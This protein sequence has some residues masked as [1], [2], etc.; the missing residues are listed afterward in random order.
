MIAIDDAK[1]DMAAEAIDVWRH[2]LEVALDDVAVD[3]P[4]EPVTPL[5]VVSGMRGPGHR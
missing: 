4:G 1:L 5:P 2:V 3:R